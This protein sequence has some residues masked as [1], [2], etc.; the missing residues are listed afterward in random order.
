MRV[1]ICLQRRNYLVVFGHSTQIVLTRYHVDCHPALTR[2]ARTDAWRTSQPMT[3]TFNIIRRAMPH[4]HKR[5]AGK[6]YAPTGIT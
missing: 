4:V 3:V 6:D 1:S 5:M 2:A